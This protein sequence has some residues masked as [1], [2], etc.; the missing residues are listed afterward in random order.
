MERIFVCLSVLFPV[1]E[2]FN[3]L[4][5]LQHGTQG[6]EFLLEWLNSLYHKST[7]FR[8]LN[9]NKHAVMG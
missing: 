7:L 2:L 4:S 3:T 9:P 8:K 6:K 5:F 1:L